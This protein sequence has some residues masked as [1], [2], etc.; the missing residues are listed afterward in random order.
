MSAYLSLD[1]V[2]VATLDFADGDLLPRLATPFHDLRARGEDVDLFFFSNR[3][4]VV[5]NDVVFLGP[6]RDVS[7]VQELFFSDIREA[8]RTLDEFCEQLRGL[9]GA[10]FFGQFRRHD[11]ERSTPEVVAKRRQV[12][13]VFLPLYSLVKCQCEHGAGKMRNGDMR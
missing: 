4:D 1:I 2:K 9:A 10:V 11:E 5:P 3:L 7:G 8:V 13:P 6:Q 12:I